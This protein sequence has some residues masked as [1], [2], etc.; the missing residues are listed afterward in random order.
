M[1]N[2]NEIPYGYRIEQSPDGYELHSRT[3]FYGVF[4]TRADAERALRDRQEQDDA[5]YAYEREQDRRLHG[6][7]GV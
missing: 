6:A 5:E 1:T 3:W 2:Q 4:P 7:A